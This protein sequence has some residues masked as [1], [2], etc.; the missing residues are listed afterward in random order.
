MT[1]TILP[2]ASAVRTVL[3]RRLVAL[4]VGMALT[5]ALASAL[6]SSA[7]AHVTRSAADIVWHGNYYCFWF[8]NGSFGGCGHGV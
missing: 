4:L 2:I 6:A 3:S 5:L 1:T 8:S 7:D